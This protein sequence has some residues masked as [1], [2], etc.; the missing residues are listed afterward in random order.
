VTTPAP[1]LN[2]RTKLAQDS[3][4][5]LN[6]FWGSRFLYPLG[7]F[8]DAFA[9][10]AKFAVQARFPDL[11][12]ADAFTWFGQDR[13]IDRGFQEPIESYRARLKEWL[14]LWRHAGSAYSV[15]Q[16]LASYITP[17]T[18]TMRVVSNTS[19]WDTWTGSFPVTHTLVSPR[20]WDWDSAVY[21]HLAA[22]PNGAEYAGKWWRAWVIIYPPASLWQKTQT[23][24][25]G[26]ALGD[27][28]ALG[29]T[30]TVDE[31]QSLRAQVAKWKPAHC[32]VPAIILAFD[33]ATFD[34][35]TAIPALGLMP[36]GRFQRRG[37]PNGDLYVTTRGLIGFGSTAPYSA[38]Y[39]TG[40]T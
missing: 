10:A 28:R 8:L 29:F 7:L 13:Q 20:N 9:D 6:G 24:G 34:P 32:I 40:V 11:A 25:D 21:G 19:A 18:A 38:S 5:W 23:L 22:D 15:L 39:L 3:P 1:T 12:P 2:F 17:D 36:D 30:G 27:G 4:A 31:A 33:P 26:H 37:C 16:A 14:T 35:T